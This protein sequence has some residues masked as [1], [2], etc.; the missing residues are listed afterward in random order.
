MSVDY[1]LVSGYRR[2][3]IKIREER[4]ENFCFFSSFFV[5][6]SMEQWPLARFTA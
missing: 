2:I 3:G 4:R 6:W 5:V 1:R